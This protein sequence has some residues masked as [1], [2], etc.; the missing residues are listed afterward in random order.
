M[1]VSFS[2]EIL[3]DGA[4][5][6]SVFLQTKFFAAFSRGV[7]VLVQTLEALPNFPLI[8]LSHNLRP[9]LSKA[10]LVGMC[11]L[12]LTCRWNN[13]IFKTGRSFIN[14]ELQHSK[15]LPRTLLRTHSDKAEHGPSILCLMFVNIIHVLASKTRLAESLK[16]QK[17]FHG[18]KRQCRL[19]KCE[20]KEIQMSVTGECA[21][22]S[23]SS[24]SNLNAAKTFPLETADYIHSLH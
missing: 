10:R 12:S 16:T 13:R 1:S 15:T 7:L 11:F 14:Q 18:H 22:S 3:R 8:V 17:C 4:H 20:R 24:S 2:S 5:S 19:S 23:S 9:T 21:I 6:E